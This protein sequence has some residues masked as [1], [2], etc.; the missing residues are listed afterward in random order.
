MRERGSPLAV[1]PCHRIVL[2]MRAI[3]RHDDQSILSF[4]IG[5]LLRATGLS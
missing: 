5:N 3:R 1:K 2:S 4:L